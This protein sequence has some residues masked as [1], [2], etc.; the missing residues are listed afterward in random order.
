METEIL[1]GSMLGW[2]PVHR[3][4]VLALLDKDKGA[5]AP[6]G[7]VGV[8]VVVDV[9]LVAGPPPPPPPHPAKAAANKLAAIQPD[10]RYQ[11][12]FLLDR[13]WL[14]TAAPFAR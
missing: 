12:R 10:Q 1:A 4:A 13:S 8:V 11:V 7:L 6:V 14:F 9:V 3:A 5:V 2:S